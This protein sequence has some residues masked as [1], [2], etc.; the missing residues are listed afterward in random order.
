ME[1]LRA[2]LT[3]TRAVTRDTYSSAV[4]SIL[5]APRIWSHRRQLGVPSI[6]QRGKNLFFP[7]TIHSEQKKRNKNLFKICLLTNAGCSNTFFLVQGIICIGK[8]PV[9]RV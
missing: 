4:L 6:L 2:V 7:S 8:S 1:V 5:I 9:Q 3:T